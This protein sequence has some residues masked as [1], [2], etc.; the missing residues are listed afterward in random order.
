MHSYYKDL[1]WV[2][3]CLKGGHS[4]NILLIWRMQTEHY[5]LTAGRDL[6]EDDCSRQW[7]GLRTIQ[8]DGCSL[9]VVVSLS[10]I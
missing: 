1:R 9:I 2:L 8:L 10:R 5:D 4:S 3:A 6:L 7:L